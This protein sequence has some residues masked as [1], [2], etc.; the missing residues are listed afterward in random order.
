[1]NNLIQPLAQCCNIAWQMC[2]LIAV[3]NGTFWNTTD[4]WQS[5]KKIW[6]TQ[7]LNETHCKRDYISSW[8]WIFY[9]LFHVSLLWL[10]QNNCTVKQHWTKFVLAEASAL[11]ITESTV[12]FLSNQAAQLFW[13]AIAWDNDIWDMTHQ[14]L[15]YAQGFSCVTSWFVYWGLRLNWRK[16]W[17][18]PGV[19]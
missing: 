17:F 6:I 16:L 9:F 14:C 12:Y 10:M 1:M 18:P 2:W 13:T 7:E 19:W 5:Q 4:A 11:W 3:K 8:E 15:V